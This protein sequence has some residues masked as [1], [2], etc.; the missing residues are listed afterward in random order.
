MKLKVQSIH[1]DADKKL[2]DFIQERVSKLSHFYDRIIGGEVYLKVDKPNAHENKVTEIKLSIPGKVL[3]A[4]EK[5]KSFEEATDIAVEALRK[6]I[7]KYKGKR[8]ME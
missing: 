5:R 1:F 3:F 7:K 2:L 4:S 8:G 6:Q